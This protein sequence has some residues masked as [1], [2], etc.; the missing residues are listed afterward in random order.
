MN[1]QALDTEDK[2]FFQLQRRIQEAL[3]MT[4]TTSALSK[5][6]SKLGLIGTVKYGSLGSTTGS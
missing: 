5:E 3:C 6:D 2:A 4:T 1:R